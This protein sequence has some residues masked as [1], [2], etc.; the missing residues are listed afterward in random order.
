LLVQENFLNRFLRQQQNFSNNALS[1]CV[2]RDCRNDECLS[3]ELYLLLR[4]VGGVLL[5]LDG[6]ASSSQ[7]AHYS[8]QSSTDNTA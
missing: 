2:S 4:Y 6:L 3:N 7:R 5:L 1:S 8:P